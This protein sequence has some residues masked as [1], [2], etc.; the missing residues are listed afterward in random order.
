MLDV[1]FAS[2]PTNHILLVKEKDG[3]RDSLVVV[4]TGFI[5]I[6][7]ELLKPEWGHRTDARGAQRTA[8]WC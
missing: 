8:P 1:H 5:S 7:R 3:R 6:K 4:A 2:L